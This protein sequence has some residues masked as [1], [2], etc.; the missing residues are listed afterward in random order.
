[1]AHYIRFLK[2]PQITKKNGDSFF[3]TTLFTITTDLGDSF[4]AEDV[5]LGAT[6]QF[7][8]PIA[9]LKQAVCWQAGSREQKLTFGPI[10]RDLTNCTVQLCVR[11][12]TEVMDADSLNGPHIPR[13]V[14]AWSPLFEISPGKRSVEKL[15][16]RRFQPKIGAELKIWEETG[17]SIARHIW[18][19]AL[20][21]IVEFHDNFSHRGGKPLR[22]NDNHAFNV[23]ELGS[24]CG[25]VGI[26]LAQMMSN[27]S[28][29]LTD[30]EEVREIIH[31]NIST[32]QLAQSSLIEFQTLDWDEELPQAVKDRRHDLILLSDCT[33]N[34][35]AL[36]AL[37]RTIK[38][39]LEI[40]PGASVL[41]A[42]KKRCESELVFFDLMKDA[43]LA[44]V[45]ESSPALQ[46][47][48]ESDDDDDDH[49]APEIKIFRFQKASERQLA[50]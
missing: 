1:M 8:R 31:R 10:R 20:A 11:S 16:L 43:A 18:D 19:A 48:A 46:V 49:E 32:A 36:P 9:P 29:M 6:V 37:V 14:S 34:S 26:A 23:L 47:A 45:G 44:V 28:V 5:Q 17:N 39:L 3:I 50:S 42:W 4:L 7:A 24:G 33:Y 30:L 12:V 21:A 38:S 25:I 35:D 15:V 13:V 40:S 27:C 22:Q 41:V 2:Q